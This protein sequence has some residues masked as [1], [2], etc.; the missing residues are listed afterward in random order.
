MPPTPLQG[1]PMVTTLAPAGIPA[2]TNTPTRR[3]RRP[4]GTAAR[5]SGVTAGLG[6]HSTDGGQ[7][8]QVYIPGVSVDV[9]WARVA[10]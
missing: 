10:A 1:V 7:C 6:I 2:T 4:R 3:P 8:F 5:R 9:D